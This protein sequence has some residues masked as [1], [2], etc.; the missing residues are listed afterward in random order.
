M[1]T[2]SKEGNSLTHASADA[3]CSSL[4][5]LKPKFSWTYA[6]KNEIIFLRVVSVSHLFESN[7]VKIVEPPAFLVIYI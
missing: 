7:S 3:N 4:D 1:R 6:A 5:G 2:N